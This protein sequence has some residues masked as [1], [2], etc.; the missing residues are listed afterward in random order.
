MIDQSWRNSLVTA[1]DVGRMK[2][3][4]S[5]TPNSLEGYLKDG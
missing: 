1:V 4:T 5:G 3:L 2:S